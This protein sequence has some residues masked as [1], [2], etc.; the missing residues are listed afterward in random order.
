MLFFSLFDISPEASN[1]SN[2]SANPLEPLRTPL[3]IDDHTECYV[4]L[5]TI[6]R[7]ASVSLTLNDV[8]IS[9]D[10]VVTVSA[11]SRRLRPL[12]AGKNNV[13]VEVPLGELENLGHAMIAAA[14]AARKVLPSRVDGTEE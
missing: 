6:R 2:T 3:T 9:A 11:G 4:E 10:P 12:G 14:Q 8:E 13:S 1:A 7:G 5:E